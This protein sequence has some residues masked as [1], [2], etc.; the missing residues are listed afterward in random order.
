[1]RFP[2]PG[3]APSIIYVSVVA[4]EIGNLTV[5]EQATRKNVQCFTVGSPLHNVVGFGIRRIALHYYDYDY[6]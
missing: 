1:M 4:I 5:P 2:I 3:A 6:D